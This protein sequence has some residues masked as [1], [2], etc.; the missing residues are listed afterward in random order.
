MFHSA[1]ADILLKTLLQGNFS[2]WLDK[3]LVINH[4]DWFHPGG[5][6]YYVNE[7]IFSYSDVGISSHRIVEDSLTAQHL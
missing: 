7:T 5:S 3:T 4:D 2:T 1:S 6:R